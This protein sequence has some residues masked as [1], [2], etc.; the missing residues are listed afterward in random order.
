MGLDNKVLNAPKPGFE[1]EF[2]D[3][4]QKHI[5][6]KNYT[7]EIVDRYFEISIPA[8]ENMG[9]PRVGFD[10]RA[11]NWILG[12]YERNKQEGETEDQFLKRFHGHY[13]LHTLKNCDG[14]PNYRAMG[15]EPYI[16]RGQFLN[17]L[18]GV[19][20]DSIHKAYTYL[21]GAELVEYGNEIMA[22]ANKYA[23]ENKCEHVKGDAQE[24]YPEGHQFNTHLLKNF[25]RWCLYWGSKGHGMEPYF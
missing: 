5:K 8:Y 11:D 24:N 10:H 20:G 14:L 22:I 19:L 9:A 7:Q 16:F 4:F 3:I 1:K 25:A 6:P 15:G 13:A 17:A 21:D 23:M 2:S 12:L 18:E